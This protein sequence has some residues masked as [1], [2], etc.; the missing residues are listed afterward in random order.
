MV[1]NKWEIRIN[2]LAIIYFSL[3]FLQ[4]PLVALFF[5]SN[6]FFGT[7][8][9]ALIDILFLLLFLSKAKKE[10]RYIRVLIPVFIY[11]CIG[12]LSHTWSINENYTYSLSLYI[13]EIIR[14]FVVLF[15]FLAIRK[16]ELLKTFFQAALISSLMFFVIGIFTLDFAQEYAG[17]SSRAMYL[18]YKD[19]VGVGRP[20]SLIALFVA[21]GWASGFIEK[22]HAICGLALI[23][24]IV[25]LC[26]SKSSIGALFAALFLSYGFDK[27]KK[28]ISVSVLFFVFIAVILVVVL[29]FEYI[30]EYFN[31]YGG[32]NANS[33][34][35]R[36]PLWDALISEFSDSIFFGHGINS[37][38]LLLY[39]Y[40][41][42]A[43]T[44]HNE[45]LQ[46]LVTLGLFGFTLW[47]L[48]QWSYL[49][50]MNG[51]LNKEIK[52]IM[53]TGYL[54][55]L[56]VG[57]FESVLVTTVFPLYLFSLFLLIG[58]YYRKG[59]HE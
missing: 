46:Q 48:M 29:R 36:T 5:R 19:A 12:L 22:R 15:L 32:E 55:F 37:V 52:K 40:Y 33:Y 45:V 53:L 14:V 49:S 34:S 44:A 58:N 25:F 8:A 4:V 39:D 50:I 42:E 11:V 7:M 2:T 16:D 21:A 23:L 13:K 18:G 6:T 38:E 20:A 51:L 30:N 17:S 59:V 35:G 10:D 27:D 31:A 47:F 57:L 24:T 28:K 54:F 1:N 26:F 9:F 3:L 56:I 43:G 41:L